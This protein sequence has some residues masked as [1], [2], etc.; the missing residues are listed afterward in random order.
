MEER[1]KNRMG[2]LMIISVFNPDPS[3]GRKAEQNLMNFNFRCRGAW[4]VFEPP[5]RCRPLILFY[6]YFFPSPTS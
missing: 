3:D 1:K 4:H 5:R 6:E 2:V